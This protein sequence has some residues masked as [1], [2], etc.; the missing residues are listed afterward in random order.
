[1]Y[2]NLGKIAAITIIVGVLLYGLYLTVTTEN[3]VWDSLR[4][5]MPML[6]SSC[7][8]LSHVFS[9]KN[10]QPWPDELLEDAEFAEAKERQE[11]GGKVMITGII[12]IVAPFVILLIAGELGDTLGFLALLSMALG[13]MAILVGLLV[14]YGAGK[15]LEKFNVE[16]VFEPQPE[17]M[18]S[19]VFDALG[20][21]ALV[22]WIILF[23]F[24]R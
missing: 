1:M 16:I 10:V 23:I 4:V 12:M 7:M 24:F 13:V 11:T 2:K 18:V 20:G 15:D 17:S 9:T 3:D 19:R 8:L 14:A 5:Y 6:C 21:L 22:A